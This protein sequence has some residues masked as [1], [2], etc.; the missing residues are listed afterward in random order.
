MFV[1]I[2]ELNQNDKKT[3]QKSIVNEDIIILDEHKELQATTI[4]ADYFYFN[5]ISDTPPKKEKHI[6]TVAKSGSQ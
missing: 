4:P 6:K 2:D 3:C 5:G 1:K